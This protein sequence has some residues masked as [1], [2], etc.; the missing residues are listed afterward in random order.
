MLR[1]SGRQSQKDCRDA[2]CRLVA[3]K[4]ASLETIGM[5]VSTMFSPLILVGFD[6]MRYIFLEQ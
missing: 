6:S 3:G 2:L 5:G 4:L 1:S